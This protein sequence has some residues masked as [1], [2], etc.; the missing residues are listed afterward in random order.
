MKAKYADVLYTNDDIRP[1]LA[2]DNNILVAV[3]PANEDTILFDIYGRE[4]GIFMLNSKCQK[5]S[6]L[7]GRIALIHP[8]SQRISGGKHDE[9][10]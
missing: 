2:S 6:A 3:H 1:M 7:L 10:K 9:E 4:Y 5:M 8:I